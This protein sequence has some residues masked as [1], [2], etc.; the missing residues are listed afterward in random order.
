MKIYNVSK[1]CPELWRT[2]CVS[3]SGHNAFIILK[4][5]KSIYSISL[6][7]HIPNFMILDSRNTMILMNEMWKITSQSPVTVPFL[8]N[9]RM[10]RSNFS[11]EW[12]PRRLFA[13][14]KYIDKA[15]ISRHI[16][17]LHCEIYVCWN[18]KTLI[19]F[20]DTSMT[21]VNSEYYT[22]SFDA[23]L[24]PTFNRLYSAHH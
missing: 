2:G 21:K 20:N 23:K 13:C 5:V 24:I 10:A 18:G 19:Q 12:S 14:T 9:V 22:K 17:I 3:Y 8:C 7:G 15:S 1:K 16:I 6:P 4:T 11:F